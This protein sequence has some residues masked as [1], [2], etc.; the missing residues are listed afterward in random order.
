MLT[1][2]IPYWMIGMGIA[3]W[4][5]STALKIVIWRLELKAK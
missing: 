4:M 5:I 1:I 3:M 2:T